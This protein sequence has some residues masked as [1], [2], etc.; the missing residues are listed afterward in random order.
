MSS[1]FNKKT[2]E[3]ILIISPQNYQELLKKSQESLFDEI[4]ILPE[5]DFFSIECVMEPIVLNNPNTEIVL[6]TR[7]ER[8]IALAGKLR[9][10]FNLNG[11]GAASAQRFTDK[12]I[13]KE[14]LKGS[15]IRYP[16]YVLFD[17]E[18]FLEDKEK[19][20]S[21]ISQL[22]GLPFF[23]KPTEEANTRGAFKVHTMDELSV[24]IA[25]SRQYELDEFIEGTLYHVDSFIKDQ[26]ILS[27]WISEYSYPPFNFLSGKPLGSIVLNE[28][29]P[30][31]QKA[32]D[33]N[34][35][36][37]K[38]LEF[39]G[40]GASHLEFFRTHSGEL[41]FLEVAARAPGAWIPEM[42]QNRFGVNLADETFKLQC[43]ENYNQVSIKTGSYS[44]GF[45]FPRPEGI[46]SAINI[47]PIK[48]CFRFENLL[49]LGQYS[50]KSATLNDIGA[51][52]FMWNDDI[53][54]LQED[55]EKIK[56]HE[57]FSCSE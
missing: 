22:L 39:E 30:I 44:A 26:T 9:N 15:P 57:L 41:I 24:L 31:Y 7:T 36:I 4:H 27:T 2:H 55:F 51:K 18:S 25:D 52:L 47:P 42:Y 17:K 10:R 54:T 12:N 50:Q 43:L 34:K 13:M 38:E 20:F 1:F 29:N 37:L 32:T 19:Y 16:K 14:W 40:S 28:E 8:C 45:M 11:M 35:T 23:A 3:L 33:F 49:P 48:S 5:M 6:A 56:S 46:I 21:E 53:T